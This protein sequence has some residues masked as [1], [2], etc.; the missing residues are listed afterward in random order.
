[1][2]NFVVDRGTWSDLEE[3]WGLG[4]RIAVE[5]H[6][7][8]TMEGLGLGFWGRKYRR[9][10]EG[11]LETLSAAA[12]GSLLLRFGAFYPFAI[13]PKQSLSEI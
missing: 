11:T 12:A 1:M 2:Q 3:K 4:R 5:L 10:G 7:S 9:D 8:E 6:R 13:G